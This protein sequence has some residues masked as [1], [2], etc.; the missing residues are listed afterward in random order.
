MHLLRPKEIDKF[1]AAGVEVTLDSS[2][3]HGT[4]KPTD[5]TSTP[6]KRLVVLRESTARKSARGL[7]AFSI[8]EVIKFIPVEDGK[9]LGEFTARVGSFRGVG[10]SERLCADRYRKRALKKAR[11]ALGV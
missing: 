3:R 6:G 5:Y 9:V 10:Y 4:P 2:I 8:T 11:R 7:H 1:S